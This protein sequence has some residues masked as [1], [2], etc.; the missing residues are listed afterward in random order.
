MRP[1]NEVRW[2]NVHS[3]FGIREFIIKEKLQSWILNIIIH[4]LQESQNSRCIEKF[5]FRY[6]ISGS[7]EYLDSWRRVSILGHG[8]KIEKDLTHSPMFRIFCSTLIITRNPKP[9][10]T[11]SRHIEYTVPVGKMFSLV[12]DRGIEYS[13]SGHRKV[14]LLD[15]M[16]LALRSHHYRRRT[17][18]KYCQW[19]CLPR[20]FEHYTSIDRRK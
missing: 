20:R 3:S 17:E 13:P 14:R 1:E 8:Q 15:Q 12:R 2:R 6:P 18:R 10:S 16:K 5:L 11:L 9:M 19:T 7:C 4:F